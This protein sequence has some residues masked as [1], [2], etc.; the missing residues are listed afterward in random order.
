VKDKYFL[1]LLFIF[2]NLVVISCRNSPGPIP[3]LPKSFIIPPAQNIVPTELI[4]T[5][6]TLQDLS[7]TDLPVKYLKIAS[8]DSMNFFE[9]NY[10]LQFSGINNQTTISLKPYVQSFKKNVVHKKTVANQPIV[11]E[12]YG[13]GKIT[14]LTS[15]WFHF[16]SEQGMPGSTINCLMND[17]LQRLW[18][19]TDG[20][21][22]VYEGLNLQLY[23]TVNGLNHNYV[24]TITSHKDEIIIG[25]KGGLIIL[26]DSIYSC[27]LNQVKGI[28]SDEVTFLFSDN[29]FLFIGTNS[30][31]II[32]S[33]DV[34]YCLNRQTSFPGQ[35][36]KKISKVRK[37]FY[38]ISTTDGGSFFLDCSNIEKMK[39]I[40]N[41]AFMNHTSCHYVINDT[42]ILIGVSGKGL[43]RCINDSVFLFSDD[44][45]VLS[46]AQLTDIILNKD[47]IYCS[48]FGS[49]F[50][51]LFPSGTIKYS[52]TELQEQAATICNTLLFDSEDNLIIAGA[53]GILKCNSRFSYAKN[54]YGLS[55]S[56]PMA[57]TSDKLGKIYLSTIRGG[58]QIMDGKSKVNFNQSSGLSSNNSPFIFKSRS[59]KI[60]YSTSGNG[61]D[62]IDGNKVFNLSDLKSIKLQNINS[63]IE[64]KSGRI[65]LGS[66]EH[67]LLLW[68][69]KQLYQFNEKHLLLNKSVY[70]IKELSNGYIAIGT[71]GDGLLIW[72]GI[73]MLKY[74]TAQGLKNLVVYPIEQINDTLLFGTYGSGL[75]LLKDTKITR[76]SDSSGLPDNTVLSI[77]KIKFN[78]YIIATAKGIARL[79]FSPL[80]LSSLTKKEGLFYDDFQAL[81][82]TFIKESDQLFLGGGDALLKI[83]KISDTLNSAILPIISAIESGENIIYSSA[84]PTLS[85][86]ME[87]P[88]SSNK[89]KIYF[90]YTGTKFSA[91]QKEI[92]FFLNGED[93]KWKVVKNLTQFEYTN[94]SEGEYQLKYAI[95]DNNGEWTKPVSFGFSILPPWYRNY[96]SFVVYFLLFIGSLIGF[97]NFR[98][99]QLVRKNM[100]L[101][102]VVKERTIEIVKQK[103]QI[104][105]S[106]KIVELQNHELE[107]KNHEIIQSITYAKHLQEA[108]LPPRNLMDSFLSDYSLLYLPKD[109]VAGDFYWFETL[110]A[111]NFSYLYFAIADCTGHGVPGAMVSVVCSNALNR[112]LNEDGIREPGELLNSVRMLVIDTFK[113]SESQVKDGM[114]ISLVRFNPITRELWWSGANNPL[115]IIKFYSGE[116]LETKAD[117]QPVGMHFDL[118]PF[119]T[120][121]F[122]LDPGD[123]FY[124]ISDGYGDQFGGPAGKKFKSASFKQLLIQHFNK[125]MSEQ[126]DIIKNA[127]IN[128]KGN[129][130][131]VDDVSVMGVKV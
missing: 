18:F 119:T 35:H 27:G 105:E 76:I 31:L 46:K 8:K 95:K 62:I 17:S 6:D 12:I 54:G 97:T 26:R 57:L 115:W 50:F 84:I 68:D 94:L 108:I 114:D 107:E 24:N 129:F 81:S 66:N 38:L 11:K 71:N 49:G 9:G 98:T 63:A 47:I 10:K 92:A 101:E 53:G 91:Q 65:W 42:T 78:S 58:L 109:I 21:L 74:S 36:I 39:V 25:T 37:H 73:K 44:K 34:L 131:Q 70:S 121:Y 14:G 79:S 48:S 103:D 100:Q 7:W 90:G 99:K 33:G 89:L 126:G 123:C 118:K 86:D 61:L 111:E 5:P 51:T 77:T 41:S 125:P 106:K 72:T 45:R 29:N 2:F 120:H 88:Y 30:G 122:K 20:G 59:G 128:W 75:Y 60:L 116:L 130:E 87:L 23:T 104:Q 43:Y 96:F 127:F 3:D 15:S 82:S 22:A 56:I 85:K 28:E 55:S 4:C 124:L 19:G 80:R 40:I 52:I 69:K 113:K 93:K 1:F 64:D 110:E 16:T 117:K 32:K 112:A 83:S 13:T 102:Q 67:G